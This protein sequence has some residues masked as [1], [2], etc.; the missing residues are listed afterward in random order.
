MTRTVLRKVGTRRMLAGV[1]TGALAAS[2]AVV[3]LSAPPAGA[4]VTA[5][6]GGASGAEV[7][8]SLLGISTTLAATP[9]VSLPSD[10]GGPFTD[11]VASVG[12][13]GVLSTGVLDVSTQGG[14]LDSHAG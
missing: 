14:N 1:L 10:G 13:T 5:V 3:A 8:V 2:L 6:D 11:D 9:S 7:S 12:L 4:E